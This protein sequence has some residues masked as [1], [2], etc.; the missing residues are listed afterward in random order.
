MKKFPV[1]P[2]TRHIFACSLLVICTLTSSCQTEFKLEEFNSGQSESSLQ[3][4]HIQSSEGFAV[5]Q[6]INIL[7][8]PLA[9]LNDQYII[10]L[11]WSD[12]VLIRTSE[13]AEGAQALG[14]INGGFFNVKEG[15]SVAFIEYQ[16]QQVSHRSWRGDTPGDQKTNLNGALILTHS[17]GIQVKLAKSSSAYLESDDEAFVMVTGPVLI[18]NSEKTNL[19]SGTFVSNRHP[20][21][22]VGIT[23]DRLLLITVDG[24]HQEAK[25]MNLYELQDFL[26]ELNCQD[27]INLDGGGSTTSWLKQTGYSGVIN[28]PSDNGRFDPEGERKVANALLILSNQ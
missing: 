19:L 18:L 3:H 9:T 27:A 6:N 21:T 5:P 15:G 22:C 12:S 7:A 28:C 26:A 11:A 10:D 25:G 20:R 24:R 8:I 1:Q 13:F 23:K 17:T 16:G 14:A 2:L 4:Y